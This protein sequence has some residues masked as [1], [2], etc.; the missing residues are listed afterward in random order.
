MAISLAAA[1][2]AGHRATERGRM[3]QAIGHRGYNAV[4]PENTMAAFRGAVEV[5][6]Y[7]IEADLH[8]SKDGVIVLSHDATLKRCYGLAER[9][10]ACDWTQLSKLRTLR[11]P[12][13]PV[14]RLV[15]LL[16]YLAQPAQAHI[17]LL[18]DLKMHDNSTDM[19]SHLVTLL[20]SIPSEPP[21]HQRIVLGPWNAEWVAACIRFL[22]DFPITLIAYLPAY[23]S[24]ML[25]FPN[26]NF[27][28]YNYSFATPSGSRFRNQAK[29]HNRLVFSWSDN[30]EEW[31]AASIRNEVDGVITDDPERFLELCDQWSLEDVEFVRRNDITVGA[32][33]A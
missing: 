16:E 25:P 31:M 11:E 10:S 3:P 9:V 19:L 1:P 23:A 32:R 5:G 6:A 8:L 15:D 17:W 28:L 26:L 24:A 2:F 27:N 13:Q 14:A 4:F 21:W 7:A 18:L 12:K 22:P 33:F 20:A 29:E 30:E